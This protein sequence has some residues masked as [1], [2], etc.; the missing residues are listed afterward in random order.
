[1]AKSPKLETAQELYDLFADEEKLKAYSYT[2]PVDTPEG[3]NNE[4]FYLDLPYEEIKAIVEQK[5][6]ELMAK[7][8]EEE[9]PTLVW[10]HVGSTSIKGMPGTKFPDALLILPSF[11]PSKNVIQA[12]LDCGYYFSQSSHLDTRDLWFFFVFTE[13]ILKYHKLT[14]HVTLEDNK[15]GKILRATRDMCRSEQWA[16]DDYKNAKVEAARA[17]EAGG[18]MDYKKGKGSNSKLLQMLREKYA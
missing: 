13:G 16:F 1:M 12:F 18:F 14:V 6:D 4:T 5:R 3:F 9:R 8:P 15:A 11:P 2:Q 10:E 17:I 7:I